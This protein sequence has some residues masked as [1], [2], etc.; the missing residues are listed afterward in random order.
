MLACKTQSNDVLPAPPTVPLPLSLSLS[1]ALPWVLSTSAGIKSSTCNTVQRYRQQQQQ[2]DCCWQFSF[3]TT[4]L[5]SNFVFF[6]CFFAPAVVLVL[7]YLWWGLS[8]RGTEG[9]AVG[10]SVIF[11]A[12]LSTHFERASHFDNYR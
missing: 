6:L 7:F 5:L 3:V 11:W 8:K 10:G 12:I 1:L 9:Q 2:H 4:K